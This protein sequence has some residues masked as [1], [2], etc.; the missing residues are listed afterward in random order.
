MRLRFDAILLR[1]ITMTITLS[2]HKAA[3]TTR[4]MV[5]V[6]IETSLNLYPVNDIC[7]HVNHELTARAQP[8][9]CQ[10]NKFLQPTFIVITNRYEHSRQIPRHH[11]VTR[12]HE[13]SS[14][15]VPSGP[16][17]R[18]CHLGR[19]SLEQYRPKYL[20]GDCWIQNH[21]ESR[22]ALH[23]E[24][25]RDD[26]SQRECARPGTTLHGQARSVRSAG[27]PVSVVKIHEAREQ[28]LS[29]SAPLRVRRGGAI[30]EK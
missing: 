1:R 4:T 21:L 12:L 10:E 13:S 8:S 6:S 22:I 20:E 11:V 18:S 3:A 26:I 19:S 14:S 28:E 24:L 25:V 27:R 2:T 29:A 16:Q 23:R 7:T 30:L 5:A 9:L 17:N 15:C